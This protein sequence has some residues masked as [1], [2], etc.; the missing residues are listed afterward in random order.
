MADVL[1]YKGGQEMR[2]WIFFILWLLVAH[3]GLTQDTTGTVIKL[4]DKVDTTINL[5]ERN[6]Y[7]MF[8]SIQDFES[9]VL[10]QKPDSSYV[11]KITTRKNDGPSDNI[12]WMS[13]TKEQIEKIRNDIE[14]KTDFTRRFEAP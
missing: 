14:T 4:S 10:I 6:L 2:R 7:Q 8:L 3:T 11:F 1:F 5:K 9:A 13:V 12:H